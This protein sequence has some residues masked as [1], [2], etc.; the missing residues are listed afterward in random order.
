MKDNDFARI[1]DQLNDLKS[2][3]SI[4][5]RKNEFGSDS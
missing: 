5:Y 2:F 4:I 3:Q 1:L